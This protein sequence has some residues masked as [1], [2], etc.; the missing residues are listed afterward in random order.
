M[1]KNQVFRSAR[2]R[3]PTH[4][5]L[6]LA[7]VTSVLGLWFPVFTMR[8]GFHG[9]LRTVVNIKRGNGQ[10]VAARRLVYRNTE[11]LH[12]HMKLTEVTGHT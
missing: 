9:F 3:S 2:L 11:C 7:K 10:Q 6:P 8:L 4:L 5:S 1:D 12:G